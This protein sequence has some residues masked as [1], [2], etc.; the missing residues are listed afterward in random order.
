MSSAFW[1]SQAEEAAT[2]QRRQSLSS[3]RKRELSVQP[4][5]QS[6]AKLTVHEERQAM[7]QNV[8]RQIKKQRMK[9]RQAITPNLAISQ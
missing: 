8:A 2:L 7:A 9:V 5:S 6:M 1:D 4:D 3:S